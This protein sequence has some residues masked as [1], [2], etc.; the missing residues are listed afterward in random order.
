MLFDSIDAERNEQMNKQ[1]IQ[2][3]H[4]QQKMYMDCLTNF[5][6]VYFMFDQNTKRDVRVI[7]P[8]SIL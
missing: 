2:R 8:T 6:K 1:L 5:L 3:Q 4:R 7:L